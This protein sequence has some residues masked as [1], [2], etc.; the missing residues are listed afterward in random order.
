[1][2]ERGTAADGKVLDAMV[3]TETVGD[4]VGVV[5][6]LTHL[7]LLLV[8]PDVETNIR[9]LEINHVEVVYKHIGEYGTQ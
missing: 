1:M 7:D 9:L 2:E 5:L 3:G 4:D 6:V 8:K